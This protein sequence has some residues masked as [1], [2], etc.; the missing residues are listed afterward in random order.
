MCRLGVDFRKIGVFHLPMEKHIAPKI[1]G[2]I[3]VVTKETKREKL[4]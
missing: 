3:S 1:A 2:H 4:H